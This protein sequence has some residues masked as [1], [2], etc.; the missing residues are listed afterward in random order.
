MIF[1]LS[2]STAV[3]WEGAARERQ[4][5]VLNVY[6]RKQQKDTLQKVN[7][8]KLLSNHSPLKSCV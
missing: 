3:S 5:C 8:K 1:L 4:E 6:A 2:A 7:A